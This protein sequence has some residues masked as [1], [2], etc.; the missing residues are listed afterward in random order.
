M[1][2]ALTDAFDQVKMPVSCAQNIEK[3]LTLRETAP[4]L[5]TAEP[6]EPSRGG[7]LCGLAALATC[8]ALV[9]GLLGTLQSGPEPQ[10]SEVPMPQTTNVTAPPETDSCETK[11]CFEDSGITVQ[12]G[13][14]EK[15]EGTGSAAGQTGGIPAWLQDVDG[16]LYFV[17]NGENVDITDLI[18]MDEPFIYS[19]TDHEGIQHCMAVGRLD[20][21]PYQ[22]IKESVGWAI[23]YRNME[24]AEAE[25][26]LPQ[27]G[28]IAG[29]SWGHWC[30]ALDEEYGWHEAAQREF[31][32]S[33]S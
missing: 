25:G 8:M 13:T 2:K 10:L 19:Y 21:E 23:W 29:S 11:Y 12:Q 4:S 33:W 1:E 14:N 20:D 32:V 5:C 17:C 28:W 18:S 7:W 26:A 16:R 22:N 15:G 27:D 6:T 24:E 3:A 31:D 9:I 30:N